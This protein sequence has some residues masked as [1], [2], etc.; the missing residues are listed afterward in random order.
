MLEQSCAFSIRF[1]ASQM[2]SNG[3]SVE[4]MYFPLAP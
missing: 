2:A 1:I 4:D 3:S